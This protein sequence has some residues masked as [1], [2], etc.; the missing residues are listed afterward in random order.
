M[1]TSY[2]MRASR[3]NNLY[4]GNKIP[5]TLPFCGNYI[6]FWIR[7]FKQVHTLYSIVII[8]YS[9]ISPRI[10]YENRSEIVINTSQYARSYFR[11]ESK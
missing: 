8:L 10:R 5:K 3:N 11:T 9:N 4:Y 7:R 2:F 1:Y 6:W